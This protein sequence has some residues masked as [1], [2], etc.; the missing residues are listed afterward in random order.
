MQIKGNWQKATETLQITITF[1]QK[2]KRHRDLDNL[3]AASKPAL[4]GI[5]AALG[6][7]DRCFEPITIQ[8]AYSKE[9]SSTIVEIN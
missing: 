7:D 2:D 9:G 8:R 4:D 5:A 3:L 1:V 6:V